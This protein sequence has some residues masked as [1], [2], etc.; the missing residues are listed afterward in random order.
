MPR[1][2]LRELERRVDLLEQE[3]LRLRQRLADSPM[4][5][6]GAAAP[7][8][9]DATLDRFFEA[10]GISSEKSGLAQLRALQAEQ[11][12]LWAR[13]DKKGQSLANPSSGRKGRRGRDG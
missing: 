2:T 4:P 3:L 8:D 12:R 1:T 9:L 6:G 10:A 13:R 5:E 7:V 11:E